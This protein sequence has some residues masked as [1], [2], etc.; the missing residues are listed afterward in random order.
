MAGLRFFA[1]A[2]L[3]LVMQQAGAFSMYVSDCAD[4]DPNDYEA[5]YA[6]VSSFRHKQMGRNG[7]DGEF[8][9]AS[10]SCYS[11]QVTYAAALKASGIKNA[12]ANW[13][14]KRV[15]IPSCETFAKLRTDW[16]GEPPSWVDCLNYDPAKVAEHMPTCLTGYLR[17][18]KG[19]NRPEFSERDAAALL[20]HCEEARKVYRN[21]LRDA[22]VVRKPP[23]NYQKPDCNVVAEVLTAM[24]EPDAET[25]RRER[26]VQEMRKKAGLPAAGAMWMACLDYDPDNPT[27]HIER[28]MDGHTV[29]VQN[30]AQLIT[31]YEVRLRSAYGGSMPVNYLRPK[32]FDASDMVEAERIAMEERRRQADE[33]YRRM[34]AARAKKAPPPTWEEIG[35]GIARGTIVVIRQAGAASK[36]VGKAGA[37]IIWGGLQE[38]LTGE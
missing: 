13:P 10:T 38:L 34:E 19:R 30:C 7:F 26:M 33:L 3:L 16:T 15:L 23:E 22:H 20:P 28:C 18:K 32:C 25:A 14:E 8:S 2:V 21:A 36:A 31:M 37:K 24:M 4:T 5:V 9:R 11:L 27:G 1:G 17:G 6:C 12:N 35:A 29:G